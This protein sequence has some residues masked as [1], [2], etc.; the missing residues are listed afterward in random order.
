MLLLGAIPML[1]SNSEGN[2]A[3]K[4]SKQAEAGSDR[5]RSDRGRETTEELKGEYF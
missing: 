1:F 5:H 4:R 3:V 2:N